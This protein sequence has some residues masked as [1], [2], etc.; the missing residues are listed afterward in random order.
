M[1][2]TGIGIPSDEQQHLFNRFFRASVAIEQQHHGTG[3]GLTI[4]KA[5][6]DHHNGSIEVDSQLGKGTTVTVRCPA[7]PV[8]DTINL[9]KA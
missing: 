2:D 5:I 9:T 7:L 1:R 8:D 4:A 6:I 3:L